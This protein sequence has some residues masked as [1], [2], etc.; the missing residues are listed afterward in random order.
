MYLCTADLR[1]FEE[2]MI[3][4]GEEP[5][6]LQMLIDVVLAYNLRQAEI[7]LRS[8]TGKAEL[9]HFG[10]DL[11]NRPARSALKWRKYSSPVIRRSTALP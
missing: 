11:G 4:F 6:E 9:V 7:C 8:L 2:L 5:P 1:G 10:D 3:D